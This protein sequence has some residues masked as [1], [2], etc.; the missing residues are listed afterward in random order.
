MSIPDQIFLGNFFA[1]LLDSKAETQAHDQGRVK[2]ALSA[3]NAHAGAAGTQ[4]CMV[5]CMSVSTMGLFWG[6]PCSRWGRSSL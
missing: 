1:G 2:P 6:T 4:V 3:G 5:A